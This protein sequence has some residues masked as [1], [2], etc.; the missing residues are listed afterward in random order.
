[1]F[2]EGRGG[3]D[4]TAAEQAA[5]MEDLKARASGPFST[6]RGD[7]ESSLAD[8][9]LPRK[10]LRVCFEPLAQS[11]PRSRISPPEN[12]DD[13]CFPSEREKNRTCQKET[14]RVCPGAIP[15]LAGNFPPDV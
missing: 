11:R 1:M 6:G 13:L 5:G 4:R 14:T 9:P 10:P 2:W 8:W 7:T 15:A 3:R 12:K